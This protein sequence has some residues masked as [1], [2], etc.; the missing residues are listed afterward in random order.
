MNALLAL[1]LKIDPTKLSEDEWAM[2]WARLKWSL[3]WAKKNGNSL[4]I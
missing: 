2:H 1:Y 3:D 4:Q